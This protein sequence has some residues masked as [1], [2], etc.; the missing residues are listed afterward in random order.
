[1][2]GGSTTGSEPAAARTGSPAGVGSGTASG[3]GPPRWVPV[4][5]LVLALAGLA[6]SAYLTVAHYTATVTLACPNT[7][8]INCERVTTSAESAILGVPV[9]VLGLVFFA[10]M[11]VLNTPAG[12]RSPRRWIRLVRALGA[13]A[14]IGFVLYLV[15]TE[16]FTL[17]AICLWCTGVHVLTFGLFVVTALGAAGWS[18]PEDG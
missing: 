2:T 3:A 6:V 8:T 13:L 16:L 10:G 9:A 12:W 11:V 17:D 1:M 15:Y 4:S 14:G 5:G 7:G 18:G